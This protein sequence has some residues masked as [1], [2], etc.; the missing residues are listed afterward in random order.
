M[1]LRS[2]V[3]RRRS[4]DRRWAFWPAGGEHVRQIPGRLVS[5]TVDEDGRVCYTLT[6]QAREQHIRRAKA[7][8]NICSNQALSALAATIHLSLLGP[9]GL[10]DRGEICLRRAHY[11]QSR[12]C[13]L[14]GV[15]PLVDGPFFNEFALRLPCPADDFAAAM[16]A[17]G[18]DP[19]VPLARLWRGQAADPGGTPAAVPPEEALLVAVTE[20][21]PP[22]ALDAYVEAAAA[23]LA[24]GGPSAAGS[25]LLMPERLEPPI[26]AQSI[27]GHRGVDLPVPGVPAADLADLLP[28]VRLRR[29]LPGC[30]R[31]PRRRWCATTPASPISTTVWTPASIRWARAP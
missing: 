3:A 18:V 29:S 30:P 22:E 27:P 5:Q 24:A 19:G 1:T 20:L 14:P 6:L 15:R 12:L 25:R 8:S 7:T 13:A 28:G 11:L 9:A 26:F 2:S 16:R 17:R 21:N 4:A 10:R 23:V 31:W